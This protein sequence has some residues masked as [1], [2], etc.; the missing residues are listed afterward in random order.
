MSR[1]FLTT[2]RPYFRVKVAVCLALTA[3]LAVG[4]WFRWIPG[5]PIPPEWARGGNSPDNSLTYETEDDSPATRV[6]DAIVLQAPD[7]LFTMGE[8]SGLKGFDVLQV[9]PDGKCEYSYPDYSLFSTATPRTAT[10]SAT[11]PTSGPTTTSATATGAAR[12]AAAGVEMKRWRRAAFTVPP[13]TVADLRQLLVDSGY[14]DLKRSYSGG[15]ADGTQ[16]FVRARAGGRE[17]AVW[18]DN[19]FPADVI[20]LNDF[21]RTRIVGPNRESIGNTTTVQLPDNWLPDFGFST[22]L[23]TPAQTTPPASPGPEE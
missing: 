4:F 2:P 11:P 12:L 13:R 1:G 7:F 21:V 14:F 6:P 15:V 5:R 20:K 17:K 18:C 3:L 10:A 22:T 8:G 16:W 19:H 9:G 23:V